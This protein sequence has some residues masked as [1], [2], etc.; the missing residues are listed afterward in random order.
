MF[1]KI[2]FLAIAGALGTLSRY[3]LGSFVD[4]N[5]NVQFPF[6]TAAIN[7]LGCLVFGLLWS[8]IDNR[9]GVSPQLKTIIFIGFFGAFTT[10]S[11]FAFDT[12]KLIN[13]LRWAHA[14][15][16][17][18]IQNVCGLCGVILGLAIGKTF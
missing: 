13:E 3:W 4:R 15:G 9:M 17:I 12:V 8:L 18:L 5:I 10:F 1:N 14:L 7:I 16:N 6:G 11:T 2:L